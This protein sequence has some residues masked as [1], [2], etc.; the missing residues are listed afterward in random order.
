MDE[1]RQAP[2]TKIPLILLL[3]VTCL[4]TLT[5]GW[6]FYQNLQL[7]KQ[8]SQLQ[9]QPSPLPSET[10]IP[11]ADPTADWK[12][13]TN[14]K[15][16]Y[17]FKYP[18]DFNLEKS[19]SGEYFQTKLNNR[20]IFYAT[21]DQSSTIADYLV[22]TDK[23]SQNAN[24]GPPSLQVQSTKKTVIHGLNSIQREEYLTDADLT[25]I[26]TYFKKGSVVVSIALE[27]TPGNPRSEDESL[28]QQILSTFKFTD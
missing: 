21:N 3:I 15:Y 27:P 4:S 6:L 25:Q 23:I 8:I 24:E 12:T 14:T 20:L 17:E 11:S 13:Y 1:L 16:N 7:Q 18:S 28:Y 10:P 22:K 26:N 9:A 2:K 5:S 19:T